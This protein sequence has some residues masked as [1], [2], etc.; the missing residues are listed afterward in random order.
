MAIQVV[1]L[2]AGQGK[3]MHS[4]RPKVLHHLAGKPL[5]EHVINIAAVISP[6]VLP[7]IVCGHQRAKLLEELTHHHVNWVE[8]KEQLGT[9][10]ALLQAMP[11]IS[12]DDNV[13]VLYG[14]VPLI[15]VQTLKKLIE[16]TPENALGMLTAYLSNPSGYGR[17]QRD[18]QQHIIGIV[19]EKDATEE[20]RAITEINPGIYYLP[21]RYL[22]K[23]LPS[24]K[25]KNVQQ[26]Y[27]L[28][29]IIWLAV[30]EKI[31]VHA[32]QPDK[33]EEI[34]GVNDRIQLAWLERFYQRQMAEKFMRQGVTLYDP[35][36]LDVRGEIQ[37]G[38]DVSI[39]VNVILEGR[40]IIGNECVIGPNTVLRN[41][42]LGDRVEVKANTLI[43]GAVIAADCVIGPFARIRPDTNLARKAHVG[44]FV[45][46][47]K[48]HIG[49]ES[50]IN[51]LSYIGDSEV[52]DNVN[53][54]A[55]TITCNYDGVNKHKTI[56]GDYAFIGSNSQL[57]APVTIGVGATIG[58]G[59]TITQDAPPYKLTLSRV[60][61]NTVENWKRPQKAEK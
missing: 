58:A 12:E 4:K 27:Y 34:L 19:E 8:Q 11:H 9:G 14:D 21:A 53:I 30:Q 45:E 50:K 5:L 43:D 48:S 3:R 18:K 54:G 59:S 47:K 20:E 7:I 10:H 40:V 16:T 36:R 51:H 28:T 39:D 24:L 60:Q 38:R 41:V 29:D 52:G 15:S 42:E 2:A 26:E 31:L 46:I 49:Q 44:N 61:Q 37:M 6:A 25:N 22:K 57:V 32:V 35:A 1:I 13:L 56:I 23:W 33:V 17:I 55:G